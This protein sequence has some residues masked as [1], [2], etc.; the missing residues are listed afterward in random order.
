MFSSKLNSFL[1]G[2][3][4]FFTSVTLCWGQSTS[5]TAFL[6]EIAEQQVPPPKIGNPTTTLLPDWKA[7]D[8]LQH[9]SYSNSN[10]GI[11]PELNN[12]RE[13]WDRQFDSLE[14]E[15][16]FSLGIA[17]DIG[18]DPYFARIGYAPGYGLV[19][20]AEFKLV[21][22]V[23]ANAT[24]GLS[25]TLAYS[26]YA[27]AHS[28]L[29]FGW[30]H[31]YN[32]RL[33]STRTTDV[34]LLRTGEGATLK[35]NT[36]DFESV[37]ATHVTYVDIS[38]NRWIFSRS[39]GL[40]EQLEA[41]DSG[42]VFDFT[43][44]QDEE[45]IHGA[46]A[47]SNH[48]DDLV[49]VA[50]DFRLVKVSY[51][52]DPTYFLDFNYDASG[53][54]TSIDF[55]ENEVTIADVAQFEYDLAGKGDLLAVLD[56]VGAA[57]NEFTY[58]TDAVASG[59]SSKTYHRLLKTY[60]S[61]GSTVTN[62]YYHYSDSVPDIWGDTNHSPY[63]VP[64]ALMSQ[65][66]L[67]VDTTVD[68]LN[69]DYGNNKTTVERKIAGEV[70]PQLIYQTSVSGSNRTNSLST[71]IDIGDGVVQSIKTSVVYNGKTGYISKQTLLNGGVV[72]HLVVDDPNDAIDPR[73]FS[74]IQLDGDDLHL[75]EF[76]ESGELIGLYQGPALGDE[77]EYIGLVLDFFQAD[78]SLTPTVESESVMSSLLESITNVTGDT[79]AL[80]YNELG[81]VTD[82][83]E[84]G[85]A[86]LVNH[87][88]VY[89]HAGRLIQYESPHGTTRYRYDSLNRLVSKTEGYGQLEQRT[90]EYVYNALS[91]IS[92][93]R[94]VD[95]SGFFVGADQ[96]SY[97]PFG[98]LVG[99]NWDATTDT[100]SDG[101]AQSQK[102]CYNCD[103]GGLTYEEV[104]Y[105]ANVDGTPK[106]SRAYMSTSELGIDYR[107][108]YF[109]DDSGTL[110]GVIHRY[111]STNGR[112][113][114]V[115]Y[116]DAQ[117]QSA[118]ISFYFDEVT[119]TQYQSLVSATPLSSGWHSDSS[120]VSRQ[121]SLDNGQ[122]ATY[123]DA[124]GESLVATYNTPGG[125]ASLSWDNGAFTEQ[126]TTDE[127]DLIINYASNDELRLDS[128]V[129]N[130]VV[131]S[132][133]LADSGNSS[134]LTLVTD[135]AFHS[136]T[137]GYDESNRLEYY[138][139]SFIS[140]SFNAEPAGYVFA[141]D[142]IGRMTKKTLPTQFYKE[143]ELLAD[144]QWYGQVSAYDAPLS[145][146]TFD[147]EADE[148]ARL[149]GVQG[150][151][152]SDVEFSIGRNLLDATVTTEYGAVAS[153][154][155]DC[156]R[157]LAQEILGNADHGGLTM[158]FGFTPLGVVQSLAVGGNSTTYDYD[159][160]TNYLTGI[161]YP[162]DPDV[163][164]V[165]SEVAGEVVVTVQVGGVD[166]SV[167][168]FDAD[169][170]L[171]LYEQININKSVEFAYDG[172]GRLEQLL[173]SET[174]GITPEREVD[175]H[176]AADGSGRLDYIQDTAL[177]YPATIT[178]AYTA[179]GSLTLHYPTLESQE[180]I[181]DAYGRLTKTKFNG[182]AA[183][184][185]EYAYLLSSEGYPVTENYIP[186]GNVIFNEE[187]NFKAAE[188]T[189]FD[190]LLANVL[191]D[192]LPID[193][194]NFPIDLING[195]I[196]R[197]GWR[198][199]RVSS[200]R[201][202]RDL[203]ALSS[204]SYDL[205]EGN[206][207]A[208]SPS[209]AVA[210]ALAYDDAGRLVSASIP[211]GR[212]EFVYDGIGRLIQQ[213]EYDSGDVV[214]SRESYLLIGNRVLASFTGDLG[215]T[216]ALHEDYI[217]APDVLPAFGR[218]ETDAGPTL[219]AIVP[220]LD[221]LDNAA[222]LQYDGWGNVRRA[223]DAEGVVAAQDWKYS[224]AG[225]SSSA[226][227]TPYTWQGWRYIS[228]LDLYFNGNTFYSPT[229]RRRVGAPYLDRSLH[230]ANS[231][232]PLAQLPPQM[233]DPYGQPSY[234][235][236]ASG[237]SS[238]RSLD[239]S[240]LAQFEVSDAPGQF[241]LPSPRGGEPAVLSLHFETVLGAPDSD[242]DKLEDW[243]EALLGSNRNL[244]DSDGD[245]LSDT[246]EMRLGTVIFANTLGPDG[247]HDAG[248]DSDE[249]G[250]NDG[251]E[252]SVG[253]DPLDAETVDP[254]ALRIHTASRP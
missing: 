225:I 68:S 186:L 17:L 179:N 10:E 221:N 21:Q 79:L 34:W 165:Y 147:Y 181:Y 50:H 90:F 129:R 8:W 192:A 198:M 87:H 167:W 44:S 180:F 123:E 117:G 5:S 25:V 185:A 89:D 109:F 143:W 205:E 65:S 94:L 71:S 12:L 73:Y 135:R 200:L 206:L 36:V 19:H 158:D 252:V 187:P 96:Y 210:T 39:T 122:I 140:A 215:S 24:T 28:V 146:I 209:N 218:S 58:Y 233:R 242:G 169:R 95:S 154:F 145:E 55:T 69:Y 196:L 47:L 249:D 191:E 127:Q 213:V 52:S 133:V 29:G 175:Y 150:D 223:I 178:Y 177:A 228:D 212:I 222:Y 214:V 4:L 173:I 97:D 57:L 239:I 131:I 229:L 48:P 53:R 152:L 18:E 30:T 245:G 220:A 11:N 234:V 232:T 202:V 3:I 20:T 183:D 197:Q 137:V 203:P 148:S 138:H 237:A 92:V 182:A 236:V 64:N 188:S 162:N 124:R 102:I 126:T 46:Y 27:R 244:S 231:D 243:L 219:L 86:G 157:Y 217:Q 130:G 118:Y 108:V 63:I 141:Y 81:L 84:V 136:L 194:S 110:D 26:S 91:Q 132:N 72:S 230:L 251:Y 51:N 107:E 151:S 227:T 7:H 248:W 235:R 184:S 204:A 75:M 9:F 246:T 54:L 208:R 60:E 101:Y 241:A 40:L 78:L 100:A 142:A 70:L 224:L 49:N 139:S 33:F 207:Q 14:I 66:R 238:M 226:P 76:T 120:K 23:F 121:W 149:S 59:A 211:S 161:D 201:E 38:N 113:D 82:I 174:G 98:R 156:H 216:L 240:S 45:F 189:G 74:Q 104:Y 155:Y 88:F 128:M 116:M 93:I 80:Q 112:L 85:A 56:E 144:G 253:L 6:T 168:T 42:E 37:T 159:P 1:W 115:E 13:Q 254:V 103:V 77:S 164:V 119:D 163:D 166:E 83:D 61:L 153:A 105:T 190:A 176:Y 114:R 111:L 22:P 16:S 32:W 195:E 99:I 193:F 67:N 35:L 43:W 15:E 247:I 41:Q 125:L 31:N 172:E 250:L 160:F 199:N 62:T 134:L 171:R 106:P 2:N 170:Q